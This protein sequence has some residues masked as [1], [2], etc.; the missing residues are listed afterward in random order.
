[1]ITMPV[2]N[3]LPSR[4]ED[5]FFPQRLPVP[6]V[7]HQPLA[8]VRRVDLLQHLGL[9]VGDL[10]QF[11]RAPVRLRLGEYRAV[12]LPACELRLPRE[13]D[14]ADDERNRDRRHG[15]HGSAMRRYS[16]AASDS[17]AVGCTGAPSTVTRSCSGTLRSPCS[18]ITHASTLPGATPSALARPVRKRRLSLIV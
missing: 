3:C 5:F 15:G 9:I 11:V 17:P 7:G 2:R 13:T 6:W 8:C 18:P 10:L 1:M 14:H 16:S 12:A 4:K